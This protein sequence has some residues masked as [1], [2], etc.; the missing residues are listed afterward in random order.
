MRSRRNERACQ[1]LVCPPASP[2][3]PQGGLALAGCSLSQA[4]NDSRGHANGTSRHIQ[5]SPGTPTTGL[6][7]RGND[8]SKST[9]R[10]GRQ[11]AAT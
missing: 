1:R 2:R 9:G 7:K 11:N 10:S 4:G 5:H 6:R 8:T 3:S